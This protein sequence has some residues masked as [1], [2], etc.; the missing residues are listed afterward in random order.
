MLCLSLFSL[1]LHS[2][3]QV[4]IVVIVGTSERELLVLLRRQKKG[5]TTFE[6]VQA[7]KRYDRPRYNKLPK[8]K[9][10]IRT[11]DFWVQTKTSQRTQLITQIQN[12]RRCSSWRQFD[13][14]T[15]LD[16]SSKCTTF[17]EFLQLFSSNSS[18]SFF[19]LLPFVFRSSQS[20]WVR[21]LL[22]IL[23]SFLLV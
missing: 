20:F 18:D 1:L 10:E 4:I 22:V 6:I 11:R 8:K 19:V 14:R 17:F 21:L 3:I 15:Q 23:F 5:G 2:V 12:I 9:K 7:R 16:D 13:R